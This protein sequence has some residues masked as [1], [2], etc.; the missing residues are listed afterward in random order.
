[1]PTRPIGTEGQLARVFHHELI[2]FLRKNITF[3]DVGKTI[4]VGVL[5]RNAQILDTLSGV[6]VDTAFNAGT[7]NTIDVGTSASGTAYATALASGSTGKKVLTTT[8]LLA[9]ETTVT[10]TLNTAGTAASAGKA[11]IIVAYIPDL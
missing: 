1:M 6:Y 8:P 3:D 4:V 2:H 9:A 7:T 5:P 11:T 10:A